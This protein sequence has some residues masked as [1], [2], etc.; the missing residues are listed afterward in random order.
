M[1]KFIELMTTANV[2]VIRNLS[3]YITKAFDIRK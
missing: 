3:M 1:T 2:T